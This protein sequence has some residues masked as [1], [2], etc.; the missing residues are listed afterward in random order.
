[1]LRR[2]FLGLLALAAARQTVAALEVFRVRVNRRGNWTLVRL[3]TKE[4]L[5]GIGEASHGGND[6]RTIQALRGFYQRLEG[7]SAADILAF[8]RGA[9]AEAKQ[10]GRNAVCAMSA[11]E[12]CLW[13][14]A[15]QAAGIPCHQF[16]GGKLNAALR[17][18]ANINRCTEERTPD[19]FAA[20]ARRAVEAG[21]DAIKL[22]PFD[23]MP[24][25]GD[26]PFTQKGL[27]SLRAVREAIGPE[28]DL[29]VDGHHHLSLPRGLQLLEEVDPLRLFWMEELTVDKDL[30]AI[31]KAAKMPTAGGENLFGVEGFGPYLRAGSVDIAMPDVKYCGGMLELRNIAALAE[32]FGCPVSPHGPAS[33]VGNVAAAHVCAAMPNFLIL[34]LGFGEVPW[35]AEVIDP[36]EEIRAGRLALSDRP[37]LGIRLNDAILKKYAA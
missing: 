19:G 31:D 3:R 18:Y 20:S 7:R 10:Q 1:M 4:G 12:M 16:F 29:L 5:A 28:R 9:R 15:G 25:G 34:E 27:A 6:E 37:G 24:K 30:P 23:G 2:N 21:Y 32:G 36:P 13:D 26:E 35:R 8:L 22:A 11:L 33:P 17:N 14:I